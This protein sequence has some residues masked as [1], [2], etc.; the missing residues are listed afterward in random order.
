MIKNLFYQKNFL[1]HATMLISSHYWDP[2]SPR[3]FEKQNIQQYN[4]LKV[5]GD[6]TSDINGSIPTTS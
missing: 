4:L 5:I 3:L 6:I 1:F 2:K